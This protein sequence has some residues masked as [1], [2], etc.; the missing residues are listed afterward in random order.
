MTGVSKNCCRLGGARGFSLVEIAVVMVLLSAIALPLFLSSRASSDRLRS[1][2]LARALTEELRAARAHAAQEQTDVVVAFPA[3][4]SRSFRVYQGED[5]LSAVRTLNFDR[6]YDSFV[7]AATWPIEGTWQTDSTLGSERDLPPG[8]NLV[9]F[10]PD[11]SVT[12]NL[13]RAEGAYCL[14]V[15]G[16]MSFAPTET[17]SAELQAIKDPSTVVI[18]PAG[19]IELVDRLYLA[20]T[21]LPV[22]EFKPDLASL[23]PDDLKGDHDPV[24][25]SIS[26][27][28]RPGS[29]EG[30][31]G[32]A[33]TFIEIHPVAEGEQV[34]EYGLVAIE[35]EASDADG[36]P[37]F[38]EVDIVPSSGRPGTLTSDGPV[39]M[40]YLQKR[41]KGTVGWRPP[42]DADPDTTYSFS[43]K[44]WDRDGRGVT[45]DADASV[46]P[47]LSTLTDNRL[48]VESIDGVVY[49]ANLHGGELVRLSPAGIHESRPI[50]SG[51]GT[52]LYVVASQG[53][54][55]SF[56]RYNADG[57]GRTT[58]TV[59][60]E[61]A[62]EFQVD[63][64]GMYL[65]F[66]HSTD[67][68]TYRTLSENL[69]EDTEVT[70]Y[71]LSMLHVSSGKEPLGVATGV[72][73]FAFLPYENGQFQVSSVEVEEEEGP[74]FDEQGLPIDGEVENYSKIGS[75]SKILEA[76]GLAPQLQSSSTSL[77]V[78]LSRGGISPYE[79]R[80]FAGPP[81]SIQAL[82]PGR[83]LKE[84]GVYV[85]QKR[86]SDWID[87][88]ELTDGVKLLE[89]PVWSANGEL[90][91]YTVEEKGVRRVYAQ[92]VHL[93]PPEDKLEA[94]VAEPIAMLSGKIVDSVT[95]TPSGD[96]ILYIVGTL[97]AKDSKLMSQRAKPGAQ[98]VQIGVEL[99]GVASYA[100]TQ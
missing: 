90:V 35:V 17:Q 16:A 55:L 78:S 26:F 97:G 28:P 38:L 15:G 23:E 19:T 21:A 91:V 70:T 69:P 22:T 50:W 11:G 63:R 54:E 60:P 62:R 61:D 6:D 45:A 9:L 52:K 7:L 95:A 39:R 30:E 25:D 82:A 1:Q 75:A 10:R 71:S 51:D 34:K 42:V 49:L 73:S 58:I 18:Q 33:K 66:L 84:S 29:L 32:I 4:A 3:G 2:G 43:V 89:Q 93:P 13:P 74:A 94:V 65:G 48:A 56:V 80:Y 20:S 36:G 98:P 40:E 92:K 41:W 88:A 77:A 81:S 67:K 24:I 14:V 99:S 96:A 31:S 5:A 85:F 68:H 46:L 44:V 27:F 37:L 64:S 100:I 86:D 53:E 79:P 57:T 8:M 87:V 47:V 83:T 76:S 12:S 59:F 72:T